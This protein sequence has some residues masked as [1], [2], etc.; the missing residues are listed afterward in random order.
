MIAG[1]AVDVT[2][3]DIA[4]AGH[5]F[6]V[7]VLTRVGEPPDHLSDRVV[8]PATEVSSGASGAERL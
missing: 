3:P 6:R 4:S 5:K 7:V 8:A 2:G 1:R